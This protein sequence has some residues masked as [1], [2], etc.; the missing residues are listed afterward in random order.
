MHKHKRKLKNVN[1][2]I[3]TSLPSQFFTFVWKNV[4]ECS[5]IKLLNGIHYCYALAAHI[6][7]GEVFQSSKHEMRKDAE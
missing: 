1:K 5:Y 3:L 7:W 6:R 4:G 2:K